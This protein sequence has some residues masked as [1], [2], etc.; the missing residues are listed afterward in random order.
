MSNLISED[1]I[2]RMREF[3]STPKFRR[4][5]EQLLPEGRPDD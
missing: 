5:P 3:A 2:E 4:C 1:E